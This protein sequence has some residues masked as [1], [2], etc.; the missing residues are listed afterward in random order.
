MTA[1]RSFQQEIVALFGQPVAENPTQWMIERAFAHHGLA[2]RYVT[3]EV[4]PRNLADAVRGMRAMGFRGANCTIPHKVAVIEHLDELSDAARR[5]G[6]VNCI[7][8]RGDRLLGENT[9]GKGFL[10]SLRSVADPRGMRS[11]LLGAGGAA[12]AVGV[13]LALAGVKNLTVVN[14]SVERG[15]A[16]AAQLCERTPASAT[17][18]PWSGNYRIPAETDLVVNCTSIGLYPA[19]TA[20]PALDFESLLPRQVVCDVV[21][22]PPQTELVRAAR[23]R[24]CTVLDGLGMLVEQGVIGFE[25]WTGVRPE[26]AVMR[27][28]LEE[29]F[30]AGPEAE[31]RPAAVFQRLD[32]VSIGVLNL[33]RAKQLYLDIF[34][35]EPL[36]D[37]GTNVDEQFHWLTFKLGGRKLE[38][39]APTAPG[40]GG[41]GRFLAKR[42]EGFHHL[43]I[44]VADLPQAMSYFQA[45]GL[46]ILAASSDNPFWKHCY[47]HPQ[48]TCGVLVQ[49]FE[50]NPQTL[51][52]AV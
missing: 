36:A 42:G 20:R 22:N 40:E 46:R 3:L 4:A 52:H 48:D 13:E 19:V 2:W 12:R 5:I 51:E 9:D 8:R 45:R 50:E 26:A 37:A 10:Q 11:V 14:R 30:G 31:A 21:P 16:L 43:S 47:L 15:E 25:L 41:V 1:P 38:L 18:V 28:A 24:G 29:V 6:A 34:G 35:G 49:V 7:V 39:V 27:H 33:D 17:F 23:A 44:S 32:H